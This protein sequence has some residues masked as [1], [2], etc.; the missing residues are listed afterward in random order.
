[1]YRL[2]IKWAIKFQ[3][4]VTVPDIHYEANIPREGVSHLPTF[5]VLGAQ[6]SVLRPL[7]YHHSLPWWSHP[8]LGVNIMHKLMTFKFLFS[9]WTSFYGLVFLPPCIIFPRKPLLAIS[10]LICSEP[11]FWSPVPLL[12]GT[13]SSCGLHHRSECSHHPFI[14]AGQKCGDHL[15]FFFFKLTILYIYLKKYLFIYLFGCTGS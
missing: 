3:V 13:C 11:T 4:L 10:N 14:C 6:D 12:P 1:M 2:S 15:F 7:L 9:P 5:Y 8:L